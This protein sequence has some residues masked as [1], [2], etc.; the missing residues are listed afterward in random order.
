[1]ECDPNFRMYFHTSSQPHDI[2]AEIAAYI[3]IVLFQQT[4]ADA[5]VDFLDVF[6]TLEKTRLCSDKKALVQVNK[7]IIWGKS[8]KFISL[9]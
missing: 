6:M 4:R 8:E 7:H 2:P 5:E 1:M 9:S 3:G